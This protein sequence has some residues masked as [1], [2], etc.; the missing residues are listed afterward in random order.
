MDRYKQR[1]GRWPTNIDELVS[2]CDDLEGHTNDAYGGAV[3]LVD[4]NTNTGY[5][6]LMSYGRDKM[7]GGTN[8]YDHD[9]IVRFPVDE[10]KNAQWNEQ[11]HKRVFY[12]LGQ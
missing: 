11:E 12:T 3:I 5:G 1:Y 7:P 8:K 9:I 6:E 4:Y 2:V 10:E